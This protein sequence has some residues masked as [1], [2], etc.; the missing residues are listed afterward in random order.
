MIKI[1]L[2]KIDTEISDITRKVSEGGTK[3]F[4]QYKHY[5]GQIKGL[6]T[7]KR[8]LHETIKDFNKDL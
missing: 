4:E 1:Y 6:Q 2:N 5:V 8:I 7:A 3:D